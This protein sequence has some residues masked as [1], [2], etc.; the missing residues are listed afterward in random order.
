MI[1]TAAFVETPEMQPCRAAVKIFLDVHKPCLHLLESK[2]RQILA[3]EV[4]D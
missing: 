3:E 1:Q 2:D 4:L